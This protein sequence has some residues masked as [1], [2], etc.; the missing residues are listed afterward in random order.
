MNTNKKIPTP[1]EIE[2]E[3]QEFV[4]RKYGGNVRVVNATA[5][6]PTPEAQTEEPEP[7]KTFDLKFDLK[8]RGN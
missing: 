6:E 2:Q 4:Q 5:S 1:E 7:K 8:P 3:F